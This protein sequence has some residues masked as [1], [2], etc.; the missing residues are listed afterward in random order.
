MIKLLAYGDILADAMVLNF[1]LLEA[2]T[3]P[4][5]EVI[6]T[7]H[8]TLLTISWYHGFSVMKVPLALAGSS[9]TEK[10]TVG[11]KSQI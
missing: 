11:S 9:T 5:P 10:I 7:I 4:S 6:P 8:G 1:F 3:P 2:L